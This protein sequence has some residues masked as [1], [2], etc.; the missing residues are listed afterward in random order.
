MSWQQLAAKRL[1]YANGTSRPY[2]S[3]QEIQTAMQISA[4]AERTAK[5]RQEQAPTSHTSATKSSG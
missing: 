4:V 2:F 5:Q 3:P 1:R